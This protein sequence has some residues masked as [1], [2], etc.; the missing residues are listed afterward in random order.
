[1]LISSF[2]ICEIFSEEQDTTFMYTGPG[3]KCTVQTFINKQ[4]VI[5]F[6]GEEAIANGW[7]LS[8]GEN[9]QFKKIKNKI[10]L[11]P[12]KANIESGLTI[13]GQ[14]GRTYQ[15]E[16]R[17][18]DK[19]ENISTNIF[20]DVRNT[21]N[22]NANLKKKDVD[23]FELLEDMDSEKVIDVNYATVKK[24]R[25][26]K[27]N[28]IVFK[29]KVWN[30]FLLVQKY[31]YETDGYIGHTYDIYNIMNT[32]NVFDVTLAKEDVIK[33]IEVLPNVFAKKNEEGSKGKLI[34]IGTKTIKNANIYIGG[35]VQEKEDK[36]KKKSIKGKN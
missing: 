25:D 13:I 24:I 2:L 20:I 17:S 36:E 31:E 8:S 16:L 14:S 12:L 18:A 27:G 15:I 29:S 19:V 26:L 10:F 4:V 7:Q 3:F 6:M 9:F 5:W 32:E 30:G 22:E 23:L 1:M 11:T 21:E 33:Y 34:V 35:A 28:P